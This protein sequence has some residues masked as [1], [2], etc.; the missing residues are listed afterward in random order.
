MI[1]IPVAKPV[2]GKAEQEAVAEVLKSG[3]LAMG[4]KVAAFE[5]DFAAYCSAKHGIAT[6]SGTSALHA[7]LTCAGIRPGDEV[8]VPSFSFFATASSVSMC[9]ARPVFADIEEKTFCIDPDSVLEKITKHTRAILGVHLFGQPFDIEAISDI[10]QDKRLLLFEDAAQAHG[11]E[12]DHRRTGSLSYAGCFSFY[13]TKNMTTGEGGMVTT[14]DGVYSAKVRQ[15]INHGQSE[16]YLHTMIGYNYRL[17]DIGAAIGMV[18]LGN[19]EKNTKIRIANAEYLSRNIR[20]GGIETPFCSPGVRHV[21]HQY[22]IRV[23]KR[24]D[25]NRDGLVKSLAAAG[26]GTAVHYPIPI[27]MQPV[28]REMYGSC[29]LPVAEKLAQEVL[30]LPVYPGLSRAQL[31]Q[32][33]DA[34]N[35]VD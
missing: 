16:K 13:P 18:Q 24:C 30:S 2:A 7:A 33:F 15:F 3:M 29:R 35:G 23:T 26:V 14:D 31:K 9:G 11:A 19:L 20:R 8:I 34:V 17:T 5:K 4:P 1:T 27:H 32:V 10:A 21:Y 12:Y 6:N 25:V 22:V 28:F